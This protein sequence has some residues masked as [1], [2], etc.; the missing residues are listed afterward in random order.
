MSDYENNTHLQGIE[1]AS[2]EL[3]ERIRSKGRTVII[4]KPDSDDFKYL[5]Y[6]GA[7]AN[8][9]DEGLKHIIVREN[10]SK[11]ALLEEFV[12]GVQVDVGFLQSSDNQSWREYHAKHFLVRHSNLMG[13]G[14]DDVRILEHLRDRELKN[15]TTRQMRDEWESKRR[16]TAEHHAAHGVGIASAVVNAAEGNYGAAAMDTAG[17][18]AENH[19]VQ[20]AAVETAAKLGLRETFTVVAKHIPLVGGL[21][22][23]GFVAYEVGTHALDGEYKLAGAA[24]AAGTAEAAG[25]VFGPLGVGDAA[26]EAVRGGFIA[27]G[28]DEYAAVQKSGLRELGEGTYAITTQALSK[29]EGKPLAEVLPPNHASMAQGSD[30]IGDRSEISRIAVERTGLAANDPGNNMSVLMRDANRPTGHLLVLEDGKVQGPESGAVPF[31]SNPQ[32]AA[33]KNGGTLGIL[34][35]GTGAM[36]DAQWNT[37]SQVRDW[38]GQQRGAEGLSAQTEL[39]A[40]STTTA[41]I[42]NI[43]TPRGPLP[44]TAA[45]QPGTAPAKPRQVMGNSGGMPR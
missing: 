8:V 20:Q 43:P 17:L 26:R 41:E 1:R 40:G 36:N 11:A 30:A 2:D 12:H 14:E 10:P 3:I 42:L 7:E 44:E 22:T 9:G 24:L 13:I 5:E 25:N 34:Y 35:A 38:L 31:A 19:V 45:P 27:T 29:P 37:V 6:T 23:L 4:A 21:V 32:I 39:I 18:V 16:P 28:G 15:E 33:G